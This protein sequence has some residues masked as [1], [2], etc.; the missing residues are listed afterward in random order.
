MLITNLLAQIAFG[1]IAMTICL[2]SMQEWGAL[3]G[4]SQA[5]VQLTFSGFVVALGVFQLVYGP[6]SDRYGRKGVLMT[7]LALV[8]LG[9]LLAALAPN[10]NVLIAAR[11]LQ[12]AGSA[13]GAVVGRAMVQDQFAGP[14]RTKVM[15][16]IGMAMGLSPPLAA[17]VGGQLHV[18]L[19]WQANFVLVMVLALLML[20]AAWRALPNPVRARPAAS[21][22]LADV[23]GLKKGHWLAG[24]LQGYGTLLRQKTLV[25]YVLI[26]CMTTAAFYSFL[27]G[28]PIVLGSYGVGPEGIGWYIMVIPVAY[29]AGNFL[30][31]RLIQG[32]GERWVMALGQIGTLAGLLLM[33]GLALMGMNSP[34]AFTLPL[35]LLGAGH[36]F[37]VP[38]TLA[39]TV[40][41]VPA[42]AGSAAALAG[43]MQQLMG[44][45]GAYSV[46]LVPHHGSRNLGLVMMGF[47]L[48]AL[49]AHLALR[50]QTVHTMVATG[51]STSASK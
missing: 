27:A 49:A 5:Q 33:L 17:V 45:L 39:G 28:A 1:L 35:L 43:L 31:S 41:V 44:A 29:I 46:G 7:G 14:E 19:G 51:T 11:V 13:A 22:D 10:L 2:P 20:A 47:S 3:F 12:G 15:A 18:R 9:S 16:Y 4:A 8:A 25:L 21:A 32:K 37:L 6:L 42:L 24:M 30:T 23:P 40:G 50:R 48:C 38:P 36:G 26:L 34:L